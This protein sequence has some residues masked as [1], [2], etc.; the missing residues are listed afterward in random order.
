M[1]SHYLALC[2]EVDL[3]A[4]ALWN[5]VSPDS[6]GWQGL[7][8]PLQTL[9]FSLLVPFSKHFNR[10]IPFAPSQSL[11][12]TEQLLNEATD[13]KLHDHRNPYCRPFAL[14][15]RRDADLTNHPAR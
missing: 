4:Q 15:I 5:Q 6:L 12:V 13:S 8:G 9:T 3:P 2:T 11:G 7:T 14:V 10:D 1:Y